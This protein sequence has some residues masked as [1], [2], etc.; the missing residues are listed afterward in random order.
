MHPY[1]SRLLYKFRKQYPHIGIELVLHERPNL[2]QLVD[3]QAYDL[4]VALIWLDEGHVPE[5]ISRFDLVCNPLYVV[6]PIGHPLTRKAKISA[7]DL[8]EEAMISSSQREGTQLYESI[9]RIFTSLDRPPRILY[10][11]S[12]MPFILHMVAAGQGIALLP[13]FLQKLP[14]SGVVYRPLIVPRG[15]KQPAMT[16]NL[17]APRLGL[18]AAATHFIEIAKKLAKE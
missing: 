17:I 11:T 4:D 14:V 3:I 5:H 8:Q 7:K 16:L 1:T 18:K 2:L 15:M 12:R 10:E 6:L 9:K 13:D